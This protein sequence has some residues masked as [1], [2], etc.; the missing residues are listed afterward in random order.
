MMRSTILLLVTCAVSLGA[1]PPRAPTPPRAKTPRPT[2]VE[3]PRARDIW[4]EPFI[5]VEPHLLQSPWHLEMTLPELPHTPVMPEMPVMPVMPEMPVLPEM[6][7]WHQPPRGTRPITPMAP[8]APIQPMAPISPVPS[9]H[10]PD[11]DFHFTTSWNPGGP[12]P[13]WAP[14]DPADSLY[15]RARELLNRGEYRQAA[16]AFRDLSTR[17]PGSQ[18]AP[19]AL[20]WQAF[21][22]YRIGGMADLRAALT[23]IE[24]QRTKYPSAN[25]N[26]AAMLQARILG[27]L[28]N[29]GDAA[30]ERQ[31]AAQTAQPGQRCEAEED[32]GVR[33]EALNALYQ[34][35]PETVGPLIQQVLARRDECSVQLRRRALFIIGNRRDQAA[36]GVLANVA[37]TDPSLDVR[38]E[39]VSWLG[40]S[41]DDAALE[42]LEEILRTSDEERMQRA[43]IRALANH[44]NQRAL[45]RVR[46]LVE[47]ADAPERLRSEAIATFERE[48][49]TAEEVVWLRALYPKLDRTS[50]KQRAVSVVARAGGAENE[51]WLQSILRNEDEPSEVRSAILQRLGTSMPIPDLGRM[52]DGASSRMVREYIISALARRTE[53]EATDKLI[54]IV[55]TGTDPQLR[56]SAVNALTRKKDPR[57]TKLLLELIAK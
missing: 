16:L 6:S 32:Q 48:R 3:T 37:K 52:Y 14:D 38:V 39:A 23:A 43:A 30:A 55:K 42:V 49:L 4:H 17:F 27:A 19:T 45:Q 15:R 8:I 18:Y 51:A 1:Q 25:E 41:G 7:L 22:L 11:V 29:R 12:R 46:A 21:A 28:A 31:L 35:D 53:P 47:R 44:P 36:T 33:V 20:Y 5:T 54:D 57:S 50:L 24:T 26:D 13:A 56:R 9:W 2:R 40:R 10:T 34:N